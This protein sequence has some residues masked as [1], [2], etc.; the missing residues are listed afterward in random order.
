MSIFLS[1]FSAHTHTR[2][3]SALTYGRTSKNE[4][5]CRTQYRCEWKINYFLCVN[6][7]QNLSFILCDGGLRQ[8]SRRFASLFAYRFRFTVVPFE[9]ILVHLT[10]FPTQKFTQ[11]LQTRF[12]KRRARING[13]VR[14]HTVDTMS[15][16]LCHVSPS[17]SSS[18]VCEC[19][20]LSS[21]CQGCML[22]AP[23]IST[24]SRWVKCCVSR[25]LIRFDANWKRTEMERHWRKKNLIYNKNKFRMF[26]WNRFAYKF[27]ARDAGRNGINRRHTSSH[28]V[29]IRNEWQ[30]NEWKT[31]YEWCSRT[32]D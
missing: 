32:S 3:W 22:S 26:E 5:N 2:S 1:A 16:L 21:G 25:C 18:C 27:S 30:R 15:S 31:M 6:K 4:T 12:M 20:L 13:I 29:G 28:R 19:D 14:I 7:L 11:P 23:T 17:S 10:R 24:H 9:D 8:L